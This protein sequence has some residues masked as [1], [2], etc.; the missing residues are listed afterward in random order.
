MQPRACISADRVRRGVALQ[1]QQRSSCRTWR[2]GGTVRLRS[3][4]RHIQALRCPNATLHIRLRKGKPKAAHTAREERSHQ[5]YDVRAAR[6]SRDCHFR[7][8]PLPFPAT[9]ASTSGD[10]QLSLP[11][12]S[13]LCAGAL[14]IARLVVWPGDR[15]V[16]VMC[17]AGLQIRAPGIGWRYGGRGCDVL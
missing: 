5:P 16:R 7:E 3:Q 12:D 6:P 11:G 4:R 17:G 2:G 14:I 9:C 1:A 15:D 8:P 13:H 10:L